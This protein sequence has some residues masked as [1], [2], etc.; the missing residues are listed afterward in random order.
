MRILI[1]GAGDLAS[2]IAVKLYKCGWQVAMTEIEHPTTVRWQAAFSP[3]VSRGFVCVEGVEARRAGNYAEAEALLTQGII[4]LL[5]EDIV[6]AAACLQPQVLVEATVSKHNCGLSPQD[7][8][9]V[10]ALGPGFVAGRDCHVVIETMRGHDLGRPLYRGSALP[11]TG[12]PGDIW[13]YGAERLLRSPAAG[14][15]YP[16]REIGD[17]VEKGDTI[18]HVDGQ[19]VRAQ[20]SGIIRGLLPDGTPVHVGMKSGDIDPRGKREYCYTVSDKARCIAGAVV[21]AILHA[22]TTQQI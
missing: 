20:L 16:C 7:A 6:V 12:I 19:Q 9:L 5:V 18:A 13:G 2:G 4:P 1:K 21:E 3:A 8:P 17:R 11:D 22:Q 10:I 15:F 14:C